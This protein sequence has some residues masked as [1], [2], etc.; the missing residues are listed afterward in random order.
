MAP[1][2]AGGGLLPCAVTG[3][4]VTEALLSCQP[5]RQLGGPRL[6]SNHQPLLC[7]VGTKPPTGLLVEFRFLT[8][9]TAPVRPRESSKQLK[10]GWP[11]LAVPLCPEHVSPCSAVS[12]QRR[13]T[14]QPLPGKP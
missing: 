6:S 14:G 8:P 13:G 3:D 5:A 2:L 10:Q 12:T 7:L 1:R 11:R 9:T 4:R